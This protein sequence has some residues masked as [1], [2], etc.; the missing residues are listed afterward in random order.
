MD[1]FKRE[2]SGAVISPRKIRFSIDFRQNK[3]GFTINNKTQSARLQ[4]SESERN[5]IR[6]VW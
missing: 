6:F 5:F 2:L 4:R 1:I 3:F